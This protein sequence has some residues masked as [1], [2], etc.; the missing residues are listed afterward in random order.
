MS[1]LQTRTILV[2]VLV[3]ASLLLL[4]FGP[5]EA[6]APVRDALLLPLSLAQNWLAGVWGGASRLAQPGEDAATLQQRNAELEAQVGQLQS[7][8]AQLEEDTVDL[9]TLSSLL[10]YAR[11]QPDN[12]YLAANI[13]GRDPSPFLNY[14]IL[15][16][17][18]DDG[19]RRG[20]PVVSDKGLVGSV[21]EV[22]ALSAKVILI[23]DQSSAVNARLQNSRETGVVVGQLAGGLEMQLIAQQTPV[24][25]GEL[26]L[27]S[28][29]GGR[30]PPDIIIGTVTGVERQ[31]YEVQ[32]KA[33]IA[34]GVDFA[35]LEIVLII[36]NF[37]PRDLSSFSQATPTPALA[38]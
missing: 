2:V 16:R 23:T 32:Q 8:I 19:L 12:T 10:N 4:A 38:P 25:I 22:T 30:Y 20:M 35:R 17:G 18:S 24:T 27:T 34:S 11:T 1:R 26:A 15:D 6:V 29:L 5:S 21:V 7:R 28:G 9:Q 37:T 14:L 3:I 31:D 13:I 36:T 33:V